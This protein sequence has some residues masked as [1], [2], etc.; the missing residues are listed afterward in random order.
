MDEDKLK[1]LFVGDLVTPTGFAQVLHNIILPNKEHFDITGL[2]VNYKGDPHD[3]DIPVYPAMGTNPTDIYG[4]TRLMDIL[5][6][7]KFDMVF[8]L[9]DA[10]VI[11][12]YLESLKKERESIKH[13][14]HIVVYFPVDSIHHNPSWYK[15]FDIVN[16]AYTYTKFG[17]GVVKSLF[18]M[19]EIGIMP[20]GT[21]T[22]VF[23]KISDNKLELK[24]A[25]LGKELLDQIGKNE[26]PFFV[27]NANRNQP[28]KRLDIT[29]EG[30]AL[31]ARSKPSSVKLYMHTGVIDASID[32]SLITK[33]YKVDDR[34]I[35][36]NL[37]RGVQ[38]VSPQKLNLIYNACDV[39]INTSMGEGWGLTNTEH[40]AT[41]AAQIVPH[42]SSC[43]EL[44]SDCGEIMPTVTNYTFDGSQTVGKLVSPDAVAE[45]LENVYSNREY[46]LDLANKSYEKFTSKEYRWSYIAEQWKTIFEEVCNDSPV[47]N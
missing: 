33:R 26:E 9:N 10:W 31:F 27:L 24:E 44:F 22:D 37:N 14:P 21:N 15:D 3:L 43:Y 2:G 42:H 1:I 40:A 11:S 34:L 46:R 18:P 45:A 6:N 47:S 41:W 35:L 23:Y 20:H 7:N 4:V 36:T 28:R 8:F 39:G 30:F 16:R 25:L 5:R 12:Y 38:R 32:V 17:R 13:F 19:M 29:I